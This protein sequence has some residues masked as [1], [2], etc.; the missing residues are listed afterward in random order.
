V[1]TCRTGL[2][3]DDLH[4]VLDFNSW[5]D[6]QDQILNGDESSHREMAMLAPGLMKLKTFSDAWIHKVGPRV[7]TSAIWGFTRL[8]IKLLQEEKAALPRVLQM[9]REVCHK[10]GILNSYFS[11]AQ[12]FTAELKENCIESAIVVLNFLA[13]VIMFLRND[14]EMIFPTNGRSLDY[15]EL[16]PLE[17]KFALTA[18][19]L[20][21]LTSQ[22]EKLSK[23]AERSQQPPTADASSSSH[24]VSCDDDR[25]KESSV[26]LPGATK[27]LSQFSLSTDK[28]AKPPTVLL[29]SIRTSR[30]FD[31]V[32]VIQKIEDHFNQINNEGSFRSLAIHGL[33]GV[34]KS[35]VAL[36]YAENKLQRG[37]L[38]ALFWV[39]SEK[40][41][42]IRQSFT[43]IAMRL[44]L[45]GARPDD[46]EENHALVQKW[47][48][49]TGK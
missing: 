20:D 28:Q 38:D 8:A 15:N 9:T 26:G 36:R 6:L 2:E 5:Y 31:R 47:L 1:G 25:L 35:T 12:T 40:I 4:Q 21:K 24:G 30:F 14:M 23:F 10:V 49:H 3:P 33:G 22:T 39:H 42:S 16:L 13:D 43:D 46:H 29:P 41:V 11:Q 27:Q 19:Q 44:K 37:E 45:P 48:Q 7:D 18:A 32:D 34:G 17:E